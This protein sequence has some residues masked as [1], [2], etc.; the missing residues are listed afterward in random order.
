MQTEENILSLIPQQP[1]F[2]MID[3][4]LYSDET[5]SRSGFR[6]T[7]E[8]VLTIDGVFTEA[9]LLE[10]MAQTAAA[11]AG[12]MARLNNQPVR[13]G[14]IG[15]VKDFEIFSLPKINDMLVTEIKMEES[16]LN[17]SVISGKTWCN[18]TLMAQCEMK[19]FMA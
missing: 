2:V 18:E 5:L 19:V 1:P 11:G 7:A 16:V 17:V 15:A 10:N 13:V 6:V 3:Q 9:G 4:L 12:Y 8:N 14:Y